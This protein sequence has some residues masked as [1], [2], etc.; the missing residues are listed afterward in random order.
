MSSSTSAARAAPTVIGPVTGAQRIAAPDLARGL[1]LAFVALANSVI[2]LY[3]RPYGTRQH[4]VE[5]GTFDRITAFLTTILVECRGYPLFA[6]LFGYGIVRAYLRRRES[7]YGDADARRMLRRRGWWLVAFGAAHA[8][9]LFSG[10]ILGLYGLLSLL[11]LAMLKLRDRTVLVIAAGWLVIAGLFQGLAYSDSGPHEE[12]SFFW[13]FAIADPVTAA[14]SRVVEWLMTPFGLLGVFTAALA[15]MWA[16]RRDLLARPDRHRRL[17]RTVAFVGVTASVLGGIPVGLQVAHVIPSTS[18]VSDYAFSMLHVVT[19]VLGGLGYAALIGLV[20]HR[21]TADGGGP[22]TRAITAC[23]RRSLSCYLF[24]SVV[25]VALFAPYTLGMGAWLG[26]AATAGI[27]LATWAIGV[28]LAELMRRA[29]HP[30][31]AEVLLRRLGGSRR[32]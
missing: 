10:D 3:D 5:E 1:M 21:F 23:G 15:G 13:S 30:G 6:A 26:S 20:A 25:F 9:L 31:P 22:I 16:A 28:G 24:Q 19:G 29:N 8:L 17:L 11:L 4:I 14:G 2:Y 18:F 27:A 32:I 7:G 12:R